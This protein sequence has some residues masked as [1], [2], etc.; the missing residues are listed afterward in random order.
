MGRLLVQES[1]WHD[2]VPKLRACVDRLRVG[3]A[4][5]HLADVGSP[6][7]KDIITSLAVATSV[8]QKNGLEVCSKNI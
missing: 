4:F 5:D 6:L 3:E 1:V 2:F 7:T 8:A